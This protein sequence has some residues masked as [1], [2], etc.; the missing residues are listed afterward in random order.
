MPKTRAE[1]DVLLA[2][3]ERRMPKLVEEPGF[4]DVFAVLARRISDDAE[5]DAADY[6][7][8]K[9]NCILAEFGLVPGETEGESC[10]EP[11]AEDLPEIGDAV[12][13]DA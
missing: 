10:L 12:S 13:K 2:D 9:I 4:A 5:P 11:A 7:R 6:V 8:G 1:L 3:L